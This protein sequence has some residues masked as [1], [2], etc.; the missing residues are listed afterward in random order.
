MKWTIQAL[1]K[2]LHQNTDFSYQCDYRQYLD[3]QSDLVDVSL[4]Q[5][6]GKFGYRENEDRYVFDLRI[7]ANLTMLCAVT[8]DEVDVSLDFETRLEFSSRVTDDNTLP[9]EGITIDLNPYVWAEILVEK[10]MRVLG[11]NASS[12]DFNGSDNADVQD[13]PIADHPFAALKSTK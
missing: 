10:P 11:P 9:I 13:E 5:V 3:P 4:V 2:R 1:K 12:I 6:T 7:Q 8:L